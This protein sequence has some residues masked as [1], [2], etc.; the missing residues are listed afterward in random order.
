MHG[1]LYFYDLCLHDQMPE[2]ILH[3]V[4][5]IML[6]EAFLGIEP[7]FALWRWLFKVVLSFPDGAFLAMGVPGSRCG[8]MLLAG[9]SPSL[10]YRAST[11]RCA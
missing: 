2:G 4:T 1:L 9:T 6:C 8:R 10:A 7:H 3:I 5:F 11:M